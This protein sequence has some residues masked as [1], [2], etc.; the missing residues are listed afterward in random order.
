MRILTIAFA[1]TV[2]AA[3]GSSEA[4]P[5]TTEVPVQGTPADGSAAA[6]E[7]TVPAGDA[8]AHA[9]ATTG[10]APTAAKLAQAITE[11]TALNPW[12]ESDVK[13]SA[14]LGAPMKH[15]GSDH[16]WWAQDGEGCKVLRVTQNGDM[17]ASITLNNEPS[18]PQ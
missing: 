2:L 12:A 4:P 16:L 15:A 18:C 10:A 3:C 5:V 8:S 11:V 13:L 14:L 17:V 1:A 9:A 7:G 6:V